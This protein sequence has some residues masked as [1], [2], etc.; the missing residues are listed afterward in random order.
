MTAY[1][2]DEDGHP[3]AVDSSDRLQCLADGLRILERQLAVEQRRRKTLEAAARESLETGNAT[4]LRR[5]LDNLD[6][7]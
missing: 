4:P 7:L 3:R 2:L 6:G 1:Y 5:A